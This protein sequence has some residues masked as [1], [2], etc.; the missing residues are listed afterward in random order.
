MGLI[1]EFENLNKSL[2][3]KLFGGEQDVT[4]KAPDFLQEEISQVRQYRDWLYERNR[5]DLGSLSKAEEAM[6]KMDSFSRTKKKMH[7]PI[8]EGIQQLLKELKAFRDNIE[9]TDCYLV[10]FEYLLRGRMVEKIKEVGSKKRKNGV[11]EG[12][13][14]P[15]AS[16]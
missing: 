5:K 3:E 12:S 13:P 4:E 16:T 11:D 2:C 6:K 14:P 15:P 7:L 10:S 1:I 9:D 8:R